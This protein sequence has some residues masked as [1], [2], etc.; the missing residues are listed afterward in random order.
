MIRPRTAHI[1]RPAPAAMPPI[2]ALAR[3]VWVLS[4]SEPLS[5]E[6]LELDDDRDD[7]GSEPE[8][9]RSA[10]TVVPAPAEESVVGVRLEPTSLK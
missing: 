10:A 7:V 2:A 9:E 4:S 3:P 5:D 1:T 8:P 6:K